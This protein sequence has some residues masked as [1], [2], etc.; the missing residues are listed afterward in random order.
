MRTYEIIMKGF[1]GSDHLIKWIVAPNRAA[2]CRYCM[3]NDIEVQSIQCIANRPLQINE[4]IDGKVGLDGTV[5]FIRYRD[6]SCNFWIGEP[7]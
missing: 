2:V 6:A 3:I 5:A 7:H 4:G 1:D